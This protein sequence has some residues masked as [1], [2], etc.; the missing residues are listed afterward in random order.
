MEHVSSAVR[1]CWPPMAMTWGM[2]RGKLE[3]HRSGTSRP[4]GMGQDH[5]SREDWSRS[6]PHL[7]VAQSDRL[8]R[9]TTALAA[10]AP[11]CQVLWL[12]FLE[13]HVGV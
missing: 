8:E 12:G 11:L 7:V 1:L 2:V 10:S 6:R 9:Q 3:K 13:M 4:S 5:P